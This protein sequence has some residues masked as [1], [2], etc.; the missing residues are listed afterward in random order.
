[1][2]IVILL[3]LCHFTT[4]TSV[5]IV[6]KAIN[7]KQSCGV[8]C[9]ETLYETYLTSAAWLQPAVQFDLFEKY[10]KTK[11]ESV[12]E[13]RSRYAKY[14][15]RQPGISVEHDDRISGGMLSLSLWLGVTVASG[16]KVLELIYLLIKSSFKKT[17]PTPKVEK[18]TK[19]NSFAKS[20]TKVVKS[21][22]ITVIGRGPASVTNGCKSKGK[23]I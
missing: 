10:I 14:Y 17:K 11:C 5:P 7:C 16:V 6:S 1:M 12:R 23:G 13:V 21:N 2:H 19:I 15:E 9:Q 20:S 3:A 4:I 18:T 22:K 8:P